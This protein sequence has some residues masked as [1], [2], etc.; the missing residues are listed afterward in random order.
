[1]RNLETLFDLCQESDVSV[2]VKGVHGIGKSQRAEAYAKNNHALY[3]HIKP[4][5]SQNADSLDKGGYDF[6]KKP[7]GVTKTGIIDLKAP[8]GFL[9]ERLSKEV[10]HLITHAESTTN[11]T[12]TNTLLQSMTTT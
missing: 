7:Y 3:I 4:G 6:I 5:L 1:M 12:I 8:L 10:R 2:L 9:Y 11:I